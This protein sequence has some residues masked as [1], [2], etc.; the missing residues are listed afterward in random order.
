MFRRIFALALVLV[1]VAPIDLLAQAKAPNYFVPSQVKYGLGK[2]RESMNSVIIDAR[3]KLIQRAKWFWIMRD[4]KARD[5][6]ERIKKLQPII[7]AAA[8][9]AKPKPINPKR[10]EERIMLETYGDCSAK[11]K[12]AAGC[13]QFT[14]P[15]GI[16]EGLVV[17]KKITTG[18]G[19]K[20]R[21]R[22]IIVRDDRLDPAKSI[23]AVANRI[24]RQTQLYGREDFEIAEYHMG[25]GHLMKVLSLYTGENVNAKNA[26]EVIARRKLAYPAVFFHNSPRFKPDLYA[27]FQHMEDYSS[28]YY[29][30]VKAAGELL[31]LTPQ[32]YEAVWQSFR[33]KFVGKGEAPN[34]MWS[35][36]G[37]D[38][39]RKLALPDFQ[40][41]D[42]AWKSGRVVPMPDDPG[43][44]GVTIRRTGD[45]P[46]A[47]Y[48]RTRQDKYIGA[49]KAT[50][51][52]LLYVAYV[53]RRFEGADFLPVETN[54][55][56]RHLKGQG[57][58]GK[59]N[60]N[61]LTE[62]PTHTMGKAFDLPR[63]NLTPMQI[64]D[65]EF[66]LGDFDS[67]GLISFVHEGS[68][69]SGGQLVNHVVP[70]PEFKAF[71]EGVYDDAVAFLARAK[72]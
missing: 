36:F 69:K 39:V 38:D 26:V 15:G 59:G 53:L 37:K 71:F 50:L 7:T 1:F 17:V 64:R 33:A 30:R 22:T 58:I 52:C 29:F 2:D 12:I 40:A 4:P 34:R 16:D 3:T 24:S 42:K 62:L 67:L 54:S 14:I 48:D 10:I 13:G 43:L 28:S 25:L 61:A 68:E 18:K 56:V 27:Y 72:R 51:G 46:I 19:K 60:A 8:R 66:L 35:F 20:A 11:N 44:F 5:A 70:D 23:Q 31:S 65:L 57:A 41:L 45:S 6:P 32:V 49:E 21:T 9:N 47:Q 63:K 55:L